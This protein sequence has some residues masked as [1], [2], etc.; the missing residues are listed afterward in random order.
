MKHCIVL[1]ALLPLLSGCI[2]QSITSAIDESGNFPKI[3]AKLVN[4]ATSTEIYKDE[5]GY[6]YLTGKDNIIYG[7]EG[8]KFFLQKIGKEKGKIYSAE[9]QEEQLHV[10]V[11]KVTGKYFIE[12]TYSAFSRFATIEME[13]QKGKSNLKLYQ[14]KIKKGQGNSHLEGLRDDLAVHQKQ[15][16]DDIVEMVTHPELEQEIRFTIYKK[17]GKIE[18]LLIGTIGDTKTNFFDIPVYIKIYWKI[19]QQANNYLL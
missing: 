5:E 12:E 2:K 7:P 14:I 16:I 4:S 8:K 9:E 11:T 18:E 17:L 10:E 15:I 6:I 1:L 13:E 19:K 3:A